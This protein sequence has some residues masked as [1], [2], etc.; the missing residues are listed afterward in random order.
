MRFR[1]LE[2]LNDNLH[3][4]RDITRPKAMDS[5]SDPLRGSQTLFPV[6]THCQKILEAV[7]DLRLKKSQKRPR[8]LKKAKFRMQGRR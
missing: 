7:H 5:H 6:A 8:A 4:P 1:G 3:K 2:A